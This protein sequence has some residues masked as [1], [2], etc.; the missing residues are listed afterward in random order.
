MTCRR[1]A[2]LLGSVVI[3][4]AASAQPCN[5]EWQP[6]EWIEVTGLP[7]PVASW[8]KESGGVLRTI[9]NDDG[10]QDLRSTR[11]YRS[12]EFAWEWRASPGSNSGVKYF[13]RETERWAAKNGKGYQARGRGAEYQIADDTGDRDANSDPARSTASLYSKIAP[14]AS[15][16]LKPVGDWNES[17]IVVNGSEVEHWLNGQ[18]VLSYTEQSPKE[19]PIVLQ[20][21]NSVVWFRN[22]RIR[23]ICK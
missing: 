16:P 12:F 15:K 10:R 3:S 23:E 22:L 2:V 8:A 21:H 17:R 4:C 13:I 18:K 19:T 7:F 6:I 11:T 9:P 20:N 5:R 1:V 14:A